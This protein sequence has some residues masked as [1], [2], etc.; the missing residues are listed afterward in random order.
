MCVSVC[1]SLE[2]HFTIGI[3]IFNCLFNHGIFAFNK[4]CIQQ[5]PYNW[6]KQNPGREVM[7]IIVNVKTAAKTTYVPFSFIAYSQHQL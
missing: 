4:A 6:K 3:Q 7:A 5:V 2:C 1:I